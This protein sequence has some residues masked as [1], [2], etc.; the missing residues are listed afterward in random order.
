MSLFVSDKVGR[1]F[2]PTEKLTPSQWAEK[3]R[4][5]TATSA[6][7]GP[8]RM[9]RTPYM[10][11]I[12]D[13]ILEPWIQELIIMKSVQVGYT[14]M[15]QNLIGWTV[16]QEPGPSL[17]ILPNKEAAKALM[18]ETLQP[19]IDSCEQLQQ[20]LRGDRYDTT[21]DTLNFDSM[22]LY[23][24]SMGSP[25][26]MQGRAI[27]YV[28]IDEADRG[29]KDSDGMGSPIDLG[30]SRLTT[31]GH[32]A[33]LIVGCTPSTTDNHIAQQWEGCGD[34]RTFRV[35]CPF[36]GHYQRLVFSGVY[37]GFDDAK[38]IADHKKRADHIEQNGR[39]FYQCAECKGLMPHEAKP[40]MLAQGLWVS[41]GQSVDKGGN[42]IGERPIVPRVGFHISALYSP[43]VSWAKVAAKFLRAQGNRQ[44]LQV[45]FNETLGEPFA[46][47]S[48]QITTDDTR[49]DLAKAPKAN[50]VPKWASQLFATVDT[51][52][53]YFC[54]T[55]RA[56]GRDRSQLIDFG[57]ARGFDE[58]KRLLTKSY[59]IDGDD[60]K[61]SPLYLFIDSGGN[62]TSEVYA[63]SK[64]DKRIKALKGNP[65]LTPKQLLSWSNP[66]KADPSLELGLV[67][68]QYFKDQLY[69]L[70]KS[71]PDVWALNDSVSDEYIRHLAAEAKMFDQGRKRFIWKETSSGA[72][73]H[74]L[75]CEVYQLAAAHWY[76]VSGLPD[77]QTV[78]AYREAN[79][80]RRQGIATPVQAQP[81]RD[82]Y[83]VNPTFAT[84]AGG[85]NWALKVNKW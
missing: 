12:I 4:R 81:K 11:G 42:L 70:R 77:E 69:G 73:N 30:R 64:T 25:V 2:A 83:T 65:N 54:W 24:G 28:W 41:E 8:Y 18:L 9:D 74:Y 55:I 72:A 27:R 22:S 13:A 71:G 37:F 36:C 3:Y 21:T 68:T 16:D 84:T 6:E 63:F 46:D 26:T 59:D 15:L 78:I 58:I 48:G 51:M 80:R 57:E 50:L 20:R 53:N 31:F 49:K 44:A 33:R 35:P 38:G 66:D 32:R 10:R 82:L 7:P 61:L 45:F 62:R 39:A 5:L 23:M 79:R 56:W 14:T 40:K 85:T 34:R 52:G 47:I 17:F 1:A 19:L 76:G 75:D 60:T 67:D 29:P 43:W